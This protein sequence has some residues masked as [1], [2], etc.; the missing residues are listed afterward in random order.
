MHHRSSVRVLAANSVFVAVCLTTATA[1]Y[2]D[3]NM[4][5]PS[6]SVANYTIFNDQQSPYT[7]THFDLS[8]P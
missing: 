3:S 7:K 1:L 5:P 4:A 8:A 2:Y 6:L